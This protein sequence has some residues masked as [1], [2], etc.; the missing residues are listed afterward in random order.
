LENIEMSDDF[1]PDSGARGEKNWVINGWR[2]DEKCH[3]LKKGEEILRLEPKI[4]QF[5]SYLAARAGE[6]ISREQLLEEI[7]PGM[8]VS[9]ESLTNAVRKIR[10]AFGD[11]SQNPQVIETI[12]KMGYRLIATVTVEAASRET[13]NN[14]VST[15]ADGTV[16]TADSGRKKRSVLG[17]GVALA[18]VILVGLLVAPNLQD[19]GEQEPVP[20]QQKIQGDSATQPTKAE[21]SQ[22]QAAPAQEDTPSILVLPFRHIGKQEED[23]YFIDGMTVDIITELSKLSNLLVMANQT[24]LNFKGKN[25]TPQDAGRELNVGFVLDGSLRRAGDDLRVNA[26]L[27]DVNTGYPLW[28]ERYDRKLDNIF[29]I[30][31]EI[32][33]NIVR[34]LAVRLTTQEQVSLRATARVDFQAYDLFL[35]GQ[36]FLS[37]RSAEDLAEAIK[38]FEEAIKLD[39]T[40][41]RAYGS[42]AIAICRQYR[43]G[44]YAVPQEALDRALRLANQA[45]EIDDSIPQV[46]WALGFVHLYRNELP[47]AVKAVENALRLAPNYADAYGLL[48][49]I[50]NNQGNPDEAIRNITRGMQMN[51]Y[52]SFEYPYNLGRA[53]Y[54][55]GNNEKAAEFLLKALARNEVALMPRIFLAATYARQGRTDDAEWEI[56]QLGMVR[57]G[58]SIKV[59]RHVLPQKPEILQ[60]LLSN[61]KLA[62][63]PE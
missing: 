9:D 31:D 45:V 37:R 32:T 61:L 44:T 5:L 13:P 18:I 33:E 23:D 8:I 24:S 47:E 3:C 41:A 42:L 63:M 60:E 55:G 49:L 62:G 12:P 6:P 26:Q 11:S 39:P 35:K 53:Y 22:D 52:Y 16:T 2:L 56:E 46:F 25:I 20:S 58:L 17:I 59:L 40:F 19:N 21:V 10:K 15:R 7:W 43:V 30:Q 1:S 50:Q 54:I 51:P 48:A 36:D 34:E 57:E 27:L 4:I 28:S 38:D 14:K 29:E